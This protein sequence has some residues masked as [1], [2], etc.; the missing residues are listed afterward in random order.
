MKKFLWTLGAAVSVS[1]FCFLLYLLN[2]Y[3]L[4]KT[5]REI[6]IISDI[7]NNDVLRIMTILI[8]IACFVLYAVKNIRRNSYE[9]KK[10]GRGIEL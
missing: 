1:S 2:F 7:I 6:P 3:L 5:G 10:T 8:I 4:V 9:L